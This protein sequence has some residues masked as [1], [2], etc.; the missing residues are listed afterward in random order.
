MVTRVRTF[1]F[2]FFIVLNFILVAV[3]L[4]ACLA[5]YLNPLRWWFISWLGLIFP[6]LLILLI[7]AIFF[8]IFL[9]PRY[10]ILFLVVLLMGWKSISVFF[11]FHFSR[12]FSYKKPGD[13]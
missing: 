4:L 7:A 13:V 2:R 8:W 12:E 5:P 11:A 9:R 10:S 3:F 6:L 1:F